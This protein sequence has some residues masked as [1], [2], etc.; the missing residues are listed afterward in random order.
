MSSASTAA[1]PPLPPATISVTPPASRDPAIDFVR[2]TA[3]LPLAYLV[4]LLRISHRLP[5]AI[6]AR[7]AAV[8]R[9]ALSCYIGT[10]LISTFI[11]DSWGFGQFGHLSFPVMCLIPAGVWLVWVAVCPAWLRRHQFGP[12]EWIWRRCVGSAGSSGRSIYFTG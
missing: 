9:M 1:P 10:S 8:G 6:T 11:A 4:L 2:G 5:A 12:L 3:T 7:V